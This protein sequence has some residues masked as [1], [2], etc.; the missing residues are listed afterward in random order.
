MVPIRQRGST[1]AA[2][3]AAGMQEVCPGCC[4]GTSV[5]ATVAAGRCSPPTHTVAYTLC[6]SVLP[7]WR[8]SRSWGR[9]W[10]CSRTRRA[11]GRCGSERACMRQSAALHAAR[12][13][14][15]P[16]SAHSCVAAWHAPAHPSP[17]GACPSGMP[18]ALPLLGRS[19]KWKSCWPRAQRW[20]DHP[21]SLLSFVQF[22]C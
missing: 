13:P 15:L 14:A 22:G 8:R 4:A 6:R 18:P 17:L 21:P 19:P 12:A 9:C 5:G 2:A 3:A 20:V 16:R 10:R 1:A 7:G 11:H